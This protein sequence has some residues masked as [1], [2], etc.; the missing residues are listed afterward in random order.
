[1][2]GQNLPILFSWKTV[3]GRLEYRLQIS[4]SVTFNDLVLDTSKDLFNAGNTVTFSDTGQYFW[5][6]K[7]QTK[8][9]KQ[10]SNWSEVWNFRVLR[11]TMPPMVPYDP[12]PFDS[13]TNVL[14]NVGLSWK[15]GAL[16]TVI[17]YVFIG[18]DSS[19]LAL[20]DTMVDG[21]SLSPVTVSYDTSFNVNTL[22]FWQIKARSVAGKVV[23]AGPIW[24]FTTGNTGSDSAPVT[25]KPIAPAWVYA[26]EDFAFQVVTN[27][28]ENDSVSYQLQVGVNSDSTTSWTI[29]FAASGVPVQIRYIYRCFKDTGYIPFVVKARAMDSH[30]KI[31]NWS[32]PCSVLVKADRGSCAVADCGDGGTGRI[33]RISSQGSWLCQYA[34]SVSSLFEPY[35]ITIDTTNGNIWSSGTYMNRIYK[36]SPRCTNLLECG[37]LNNSDL[38]NANPTGLEVASDGDCWFCLSYPGVSSVKKIVKLD[39]NDGSTKQTISDTNLSRNFPLGNSVLTSMALDEAQNVIWVG[40]MGQNL[41]GSVLGWVAKFDITTNN[42]ILRI[43]GFQIPWVAINPNDDY[44]WVTDVYTK[45]IVKISPGGTVTTVVSSG[46]VTPSYISLDPTGGYAW[47]AD[48][49]RVVKISLDNG[50]EV[51][52]SPAGEFQYVMSVSADILDGGCWVSERVLNPRLVKLNASGGYEFEVKGFVDPYGIAVDPKP[53]P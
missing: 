4:K 18:S 10:W 5:R 41:D 22:Y 36:I 39:K 33:I 7:I 11:D 48:S 32:A 2:V 26:D 44:C 38:D 9:F 3:M 42:C 24:H 43:P 17:Y 8:I 47:I 13:A 14:T 30:Y 50:S 45:K 52:E 51:C 23:V 16:D 28:S 37:N 20:K 40:E 21:R 12:F 49:S 6:V 27:D 15:S 25:S 29:P 46:L 1:M 35:M 34:R 31:G 53:D 19:S